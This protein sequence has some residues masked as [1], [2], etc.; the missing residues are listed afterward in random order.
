MNICIFGCG[1][2]GLSSAVSFCNMEH[3]VYCVDKN[4]YKITNLKNGILDNYEPDLSELILK[5]IKKNK[6]SFLTKFEIKNNTD[7]FII[8]VNTTNNK[9]GE[10]DITN[11][12]DVISQIVQSISKYSVILIRSTMPIGATKSLLAEFKNKTSVGFDIVY[13][14]EFISRGSALY[15]FNHP[16]RIVIGSSS[17]KAIDLVKKLYKPLK[18]KYIVTDENSSELIK[19]ASNS[20]LAVKISFI[21]EIANLA[22]ETNCNIEDVI[23]GLETDKR[24]GGHFLNAGIGYGGNALTKDTAAIIKMADRLKVSLNTIKSARITNEDQKRRFISAIMKFYNYNIENKVF[25]LWGLSYKPNTSDTREAPS[26]TVIDTLTRYG[27]TVKAY[28]AKAVNNNIN[29]LKT[30][31]DTVIGSDALIICTEWDEFKNPDFEFLA[32]NLKDKVI[33]DARNMYLK[34]DI[35]KYNLK[36]HYIGKPNEQY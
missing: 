14:P 29:Q 21:N 9:N 7:V 32:N 1:H 27:A 13:N 16:Q 28:D 22:S 31:E 2:K 35:F 25:A 24:I 18:P 8:A 15:D 30:K 3:N 17:K 33:F 36:Y 11:I 20:F 19:Y 23:K 10:I 4:D 26:N 34:N 12:K 5:H 6:L